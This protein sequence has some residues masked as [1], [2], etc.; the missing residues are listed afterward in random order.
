MDSGL[1][2]LLTLL[3]QFIWVPI[4]VILW[5]HNSRIKHLEVED[6]LNYREFINQIT[7]IKD[8]LTA[9]AIKMGIEEERRK[10]NDG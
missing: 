1:M 7:P 4:V 8:T 9:I 2:A 6:T 3:V 10:K 5:H